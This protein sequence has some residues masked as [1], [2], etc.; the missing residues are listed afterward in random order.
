M[1]QLLAGEHARVAVALWAEVPSVA[2][3]AVEVALVVGDLARLEQLA[4]AGALEAELV[5]DLV[6]RAYLLGLV[7]ARLTLVALGRLRCEARL[8]AR[9]QTAQL[10]VQIGGA[11]ADCRS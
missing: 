1:L 5:E 11:A 3:A 4:A 2:H 7:H 10:R 9:Q 8:L 6:G